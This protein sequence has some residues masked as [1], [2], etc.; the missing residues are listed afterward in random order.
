M[1]AVK[2]RPGNVCAQTRR[3]WLRA[4]ALGAAGAGADV[5]RWETPYKYGKLVLSASGEEGAFDSRAV[6]CPF[7]F[8]HEGRFYMLYLGFDGIGYQTGLASSA[9]LTDWKRLGCILKRD[10][11]NPVT[12]Y[13]IA[14][15]WILRENELRSPGRLRK[16]G[17]RYLGVFH[18]YPKPGYESGP[19]VIGLCWGRNLLDWEVGDVI[20]RPQDGAWW[21]EGGLYKPCLV[22]HGGTYYLF[23][24]AKTKDLPR[25]RGGG[26]RE[27][28]G[29]A[30]SPDL[31]RW[32]RYE[33]NPIIVNGPP[34]SWDE[35]FAADPCVVRD[36]EQ[37]VFFY[38][39]LDRKGVARD[40]VAAGKDPFRPV[41]VEKILI[42]VGPPG[43]VDSTY[44]HKPSVI[45][46]GGALYHFYCAV[47]GKWPDESRG[48]S[49]ARSV[50]WD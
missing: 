31:K 13:N 8:F 4:L 46:H 36:G 12:R 10:P 19:A 44:A 6:D 37:W 20:L 24:N 50:P 35:R 9:N 11:S 3:Q 22:E 7:V 33:G 30:T 48:I 39:G 32:T 14:M 25:E 5:G 15:N 34:G 21:E 27:Q 18:A 29:V 47:S 16:V 26:W 41:K 40:L 23:Y 43:A 1:R 17:G 28:I 45:Y 42:D 38:Y 2:R 49:V